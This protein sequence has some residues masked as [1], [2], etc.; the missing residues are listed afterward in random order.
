MVRSVASECLRGFLLGDPAPVEKATDLAE[1]QRRWSQQEPEI[2]FLSPET[3]R[4]LLADFL[5]TR[6]GLVGVEE[7]SRQIEAIS[8]RLEIRVTG[9]RATVSLPGQEDALELRKRDGM[10][11][12]VWFPAFA[13]G[14]EGRREGRRP[15][16]PGNPRWRERP[17]GG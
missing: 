2:S 6:A 9:D 7:G 15:A 1:M 3:L 12:V 13:Q 14:P 16:A 11:K 8:P 10:W 17:R 5:R 4:G